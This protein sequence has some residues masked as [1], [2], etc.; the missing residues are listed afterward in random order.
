MNVLVIDPARSTGYCIFYFNK[1]TKEVD[2]KKWGFIEIEDQ[3]YKGDE[4]IDMYAQV[5]QLIKENNVSQ[6]AIEDY[7]FS[8]KS[9][10]G[11]TLNCA[12][13]AVIHMKC[14]DLKLPYEI[15]NITL[16]KKFI[17]GRSTS[18]KDQKAKWGKEASKKLMTQES[19]WNKWQIKFPNHSISKKTG[20]PI[21]F[22]YDIV[23]AVAMAIFYGSIYLNAKNIKYS[24]IINEDVVYKKEPKGLFDYG[25]K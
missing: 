11:S 6:V 24:V 4:Y 22:K 20:K 1:K 3:E 25:G 18:T 10:Q 13:R 23:D 9:S 21:K 7:F 16:W 19:L 15:L 17:N 2:I 14:R 5:D 8:R 12:Y